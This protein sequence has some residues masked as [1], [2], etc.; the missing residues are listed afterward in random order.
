MTIKTLGFRNFLRFFEESQ[1][2]L[3]D[4]NSGG[5]SLTLALAP[6]D[7]GKTSVMRGLEFLFYGEVEGKGGEVTLA[8]L[9]NNE[10]F[11]LAKGKSVSGYVEA[12]LQ[13]GDQSIAVRREICVAPGSGNQR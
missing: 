6:N 11:R 12:R 3:D 2:S 8:E 9:V 5:S 1:L 10:A 4:D 13:T 7:A